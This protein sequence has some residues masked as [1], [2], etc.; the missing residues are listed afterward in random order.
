MSSILRWHAGELHAG[1][2]VEQQAHSLA[3]AIVAADSWLVRDGAVL[4]IDLHRTRFLDAVANTAD[5]NAFWDAAVTA[6]PRKGE[7][8]PRVELRLEDDGLVFEL[9]LR[10][11]PER[12]RSVVLATFDGIDPRQSPAIKGPNTDELLA[13]RSAV[14]ARGADEAVILSPEGSV[15]EGAYSALLWWRGDALCS[16]SPELARVDSVTARSVIALA[17]ALGL[18]VLY[19][20]VTPADLDGLEIWALSALH[21]IRLVTGWIDGPAPA[22][23]PGRLAVWRTRLDRLARQ[24]PEPG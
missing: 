1:E 15:I 4:A 16:P 3:P 19:E 6:I 2:M 5:A 20:S 18:D 10:E 8:F 23:L 14:R 7:W 17:T 12:T 21:G 24:L 13:A 9:L 11:A 22:E